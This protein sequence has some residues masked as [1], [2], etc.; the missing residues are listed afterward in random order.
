MR[1]SF[2]KA[3]SISLAAYAA[4]ILIGFWGGF[5]FTLFAVPVFQITWTLCCIIRIIQL[6]RDG[7]QKS[8]AQPY[9]RESYGFWLGGLTSSLA[10]LAVVVVATQAV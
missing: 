3:T 6:R 9:D 10:L 5:Q 2:W 8:D 4:A 1:R 7:S